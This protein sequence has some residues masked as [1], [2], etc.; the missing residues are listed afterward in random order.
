[1]KQK[2]F[3]GI[4][5]KGKKKI[6]PQETTKWSKLSIIGFF[7]VFFLPAIALLVNSIALF[8]TIKFKVKGKELAI[9]SIIMSLILIW[10]KAI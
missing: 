7:L 8:I 5:M 9:L 3:L 2:R 4:K 6:I 10:S 1:M